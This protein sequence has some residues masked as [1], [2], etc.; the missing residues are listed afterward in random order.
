MVCQCAEPRAIAHACGEQRRR[1]PSAARPRPCAATCRA[2]RCF[3]AAGAAGGCMMPRSAGSAASA[4]PGRPSV[5]RLIHRMWIGSSGI[6]RPRNGARKIVQISPALLV[7]TYL[8]N[9]R[10]LSKMRRPSRTA[11]D[12]RREVVVEQHHVRR[13][14]RHVG[15]AL[16]HRDAD[17][18]ALERRRVVDAVAGHRDELAR[19]LQRLDDRGSSA[20][21]RRARRR[22]RARPRR[23]C[24][25]VDELRQLGARSSRSSPSVDD[26]ELARR[27][28]AP[29][30]DGR[31]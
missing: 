10:M 6:G 22:A 11:C 28:R 29:W 7:I 17:V 3:P 1:R 15:A 27:S 23:E 16:A 14:A 20:P 2:R 19:V 5:T 31:R 21:G 12:D 8:M 9:L 13:L 25:R 4:S 30:P 24:A 18:R 26:A